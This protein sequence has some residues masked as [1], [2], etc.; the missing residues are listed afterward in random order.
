MSASE[1]APLTEA[2]R[3]LKEAILVSVAKRVICATIPDNLI[4]TLARTRSAP[5]AVRKLKRA[6]FVSY[7]WRKLKRVQRRRKAMSRAT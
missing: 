2:L 5:E 7:H 3:E 4:L 6:Y 1:S